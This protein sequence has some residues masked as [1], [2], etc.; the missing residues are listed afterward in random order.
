MSQMNK[1][2]FFF[3]EKE[4]AANSYFERHLLLFHL[5][6]A[7]FVRLQMLDAYVLFS[8]GRKPFLG[9]WNNGTVR[10]NVYLSIFLS[11]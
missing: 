7:H 5:P 11:A 10:L 6:L 1:I 4:V 3:Y 2:R 8:T 9:L